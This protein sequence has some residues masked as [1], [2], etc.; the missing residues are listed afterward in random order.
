MLR[1][2]QEAMEG[3]KKHLFGRTQP[4]NYLFIG[5]KIGNRFSPKMDHL[6]CFLPGT[7]AL[8]HSQGKL[9]QGTLFYYYCSKYQ[10]IFK[11]LKCH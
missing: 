6:V 4:N 5:E 7:L 1:D 10:I 2:F 11:M 3:V 8:A 9:E